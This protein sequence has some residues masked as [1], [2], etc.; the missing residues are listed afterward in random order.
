MSGGSS[1]WGKNRWIHQV[2]AAYAAE[3]SH[4]DANDIE[5][6]AGDPAGFLEPDS[7]SDQDEEEDL[8]YFSFEDSSSES[9]FNESGDE[10][11]AAPEMEVMEEGNEEAQEQDPQEPIHLTVVE[12]LAKLGFKFNLPHGAIT[13]FGQILKEDFKYDIKPDARSTMRTTRKRP[14]S[15]HFHHFGLVKGLRMKLDSGLKADDGV[16]RINTNVDGIP[17]FKKSRSKIQFWPILAQAMDC[18]DS[19]PFE[20]SVY[21]GKTK[22]P[23]VDDFM[24]PFLDEAIDLSEN[25]LVWRGKHYRV[26]FRAMICDAQA[27]YFIKC[28]TSHSGRYGCERCHQRGVKVR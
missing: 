25:G 20:V 11:E 1:R 15:A 3:Q 9:D 16:I 14:Q 21:C 17:V 22:P 23:S 8:R 12:K 26:E 5:P 2:V 24:Q 28:I 18:N 19:E 13:G 6:D 7:S 10:D 27:R 4:R